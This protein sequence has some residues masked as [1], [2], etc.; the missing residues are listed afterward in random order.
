[1]KLK[2]QEA[3]VNERTVVRKRDSKAFTF[4]EQPALVDL[5]NGERRVVNVSLEEGQA[6]Y[7]PGDYDILDTSFYVDQNGRLAIG[8][9]HLAPARPGVVEGRRQAG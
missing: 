6:P 5:P 8:R 1:M 9:L 7:Q 2:V 4:R 3:K